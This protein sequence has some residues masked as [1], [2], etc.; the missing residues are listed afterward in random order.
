MK[1]LLLILILTAMSASSIA[2]WVEVGRGEDFVV[3]YDDATIRKSGNIVKIWSL[4]DYKTA[5]G[6]VEFRSVTLESEYDCIKKQS[7][8]LFISFYQK[9]IGSGT[10]IRKDNEPGKWLPISS[11]TIKES[12]WKIACLK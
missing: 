4:H 1:K 9:N 8:R 6:Q 10:T 12:I 11:G 2:G 5:R 3:Y 7:R